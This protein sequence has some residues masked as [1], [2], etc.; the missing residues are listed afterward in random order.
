[1]IKLPIPSLEGLTTE[2]LVF[3]RPVLA[4]RNWW[5]EYINDPKAIRFMPFTVGSEAHAELFIQRSIDRAARDGSGLHVITDRIT[6]APVGMV[7]LLT[8][9]VAG[10]ME[11][12]IGYHLVPSAWGQGFATEAAIACKAFAKTHQLAPTIVSLIDPGNTSSQAV[13]KRNG[14]VFDKRGV[15]RGEEVLVFRVSILE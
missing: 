5:M 10:V 7:G 8:Q 6:N 15:H 12:E 13:A 2:R 1:V 14:M 4:D 3:R 11:L 9:E